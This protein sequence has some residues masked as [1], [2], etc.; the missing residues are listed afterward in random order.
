VLI[1]YFQIPS[2]P[3]V[4]SFA[5]HPFG[6]LVAGGII[7]GAKL[8]QRRGARLGLDRELVGRMIFASVASGLIIAHVVDVA[9]YQSGDLE[10]RFYSLIDPR[11]GL[12]SMGGF[13]GAV[14]GLWLWCRRNGQEVLAYADS[15][16][17]GLALGWVLGRLGCFVAH[18]H[19]GDLTQFFLGVDY[20]CPRPPCAKVEGWIFTG[21]TYRRHDLGFYEALVAA[22]LTGLYLIAER[23]RPRKGFFVATIA[24]YYGP[25]RFFLDY[26]RAQ[27]VE[28]ADPRWLLGWTPAQYAAI[29]VTLVGIAL[30]VHVARRPAEYPSS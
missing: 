4:G 2:I 16:A 25:I 18:D 23:F 24:L 13:A 6:V 7:A 19:P 28:G 3:L 20:P 1:P 14:L 11:T 12:S 5:I 17:F 8:T 26:L 27:D 15:L 30:A 22:V 9:L 29:L 21:A 10:K